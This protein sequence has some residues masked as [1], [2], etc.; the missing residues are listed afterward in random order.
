MYPEDIFYPLSPMFSTFDGKMVNVVEN[1]E[2]FYYNCFTAP[3]LNTTNQ[4]EVWSSL[5]T[6]SWCPP[7]GAGAPPPSPPRWAWQG[8]GH[9]PAP[10]HT[11]ATR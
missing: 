4:Y 6:G 7:A 2:C 1:A 3:T 11:P 9:R 8:A 5:S 10:A